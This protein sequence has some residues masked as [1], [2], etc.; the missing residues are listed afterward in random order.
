VTSLYYHAETDAIPA[1]NGKSIT[2]DWGNRRAFSVL[3]K[4]F[5]ILYS[6]FKAEGGRFA[7]FSG[8]V[9]LEDPASTQATISFAEGSSKVE[10][11][12]RK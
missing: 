6:E 3:N 2:W 9:T 10:I 8:P 12:G 1:H 7:E 11:P 5:K 4:P